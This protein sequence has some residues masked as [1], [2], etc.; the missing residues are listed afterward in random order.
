MPKSFP[1]DS[2]MWLCLERIFNKITKL[3][4]SQ[5]DGSQSSTSSV[6]I[7]KGTKTQ[8]YTK[9]SHGV[10]CKPRTGFCKKDNTGAKEMLSD[11]QQL[12]LMQN[13]LVGFLGPILISWHPTVT[14]VLTPSSGYSGHLHAHGIYTNR[15]AHTNTYIF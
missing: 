6:V 15:H 9:Q 3:T 7:R 13:T 4:M 5:L 2:R 12:L 8:T 11:E 1:W 10:I 14:P